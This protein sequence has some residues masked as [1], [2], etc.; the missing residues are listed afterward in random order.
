MELQLAVTRIRLKR[1][2]RMN[3]R[4]PTN[5]RLRI[6]LILSTLVG[7]AWGFLLN[8]LLTRLNSYQSP[9]LV[10]GVALP[11]AFFGSM[12]TGLAFNRM[13]Q[14]WHKVA[15]VLVALLVVAAGV[16]A[17]VLWGVIEQERSLVQLITATGSYIWNLEWLMAMV[18][19]FAGMWPRW[20]MPFFR[21]FGRV[22]SQL[23]ARPLQFFE[24]V[25]RLPLLFL[26]WLGD[27]LVRIGHAA[28][29]LPSR[30]LQYARGASWKIERAITRLRSTRPVVRPRHPRQAT[31]AAAEFL[32]RFKRRQPKRATTLARANGADEALRITG[33]IED[34]CPYCFDIVKRNDPR[35]VRLCEICGTPHHADCWAI[36]GKCQVPHQNS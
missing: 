4:Q 1:T 30:W 9:W 3:T 6:G 26:H 13:L 21:G 23:L 25:G 36:T 16:P 33:L 5:W 20:T 22:G 15:R 19:L 24:W 12:I 18:G 34:R 11:L 2:R 10:L 17:G 35:G 28:L 14:S 32:R 8:A 7:V 29:W 31:N 27:L